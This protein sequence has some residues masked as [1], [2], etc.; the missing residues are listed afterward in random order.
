[1]AVGGS[2]S[3][4]ALVIGTIGF[5]TIV[6]PTA[7]YKKLL[8]GSAWFAALA[9]S[10]FARVDLVAA[11]G[12]DFTPQHRAELEACHIG[13]D[14]LYTSP[15]KATFAWTGSYGENFE[16]RKTLSLELNAL[17]D[18]DPVIPSTARQSAFAMLCNFEPRLQ[19]IALDRLS[20]GCFVLFD[21]IDYWIE[22]EFEAIRGLI[23]RCDLLLVNDEE[24]SLLT[25]TGDLNA[26]GRALI[27]EGAGAVIIKRGS[28]GSLLVHPEGIYSQTACQALVVRDPTGAGDSFG[29]A[30]LGRLV[31]TGL[32]SFAAIKEA[33]AWGAVIASF[34]VEDF[35]AKRLLALS[36]KDVAQ[37]IA[38]N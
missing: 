9:A 5:D 22:H 18:F 19:M 33:M 17:E 16:T 32:T 26:A 24:V 36:D 14:G 8:G 20:P 37:R 13:L 25:G 3:G 7:Q 34:T 4:T 12:Y 38:G 23:K 10:R 35:S 1:M 6:T 21:T 28:A 30:I 11:V 31:Q 29:G 15:H 27:A 2:Q